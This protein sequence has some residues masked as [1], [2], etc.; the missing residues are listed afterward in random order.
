MS[1]PFIIDVQ[2]VAVSSDRSASETPHVYTSN[3]SGFS[4]GPSSTGTYYEPHYGRT[5]SSNQTTNGA[6]SA[7]GGVVG[8]IAE[9]VAGGA[10][11]LVGIPMLVLPGPGLIAIGAGG[12]LVYNGVK[13]VTGKK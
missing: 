9:C 5:N 3:Q 7:L 8:G 6:P 10:L 13:R 11:V 2:P 12:A 1:A 4:Q